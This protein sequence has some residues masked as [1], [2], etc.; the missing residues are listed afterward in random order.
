MH[1]AKKKK[2]E[3]P[4]S[5]VGSCFCRNTS[6]LISRLSSWRAGSW[7]KTSTTAST[8]CG[9]ERRRW[10]SAPR[11]TPPIF[12]CLAETS[13]VWRDASLGASWVCVQPI[14]PHQGERCFSGSLLGSDGSSLPSWASSQSAWGALRQS[15]K[16]LS[17]EFAVLSD[18]A[19]QQVEPLSPPSLHPLPWASKTFGNVHRGAGKRTTSWK[20]STFSWICSSR[21][22]W[23]FCFNGNCYFSVTYKKKTKNV[24][25]DLCERHEKGVLHEHQR[26][27]HKYSVMK[28][29]MMSA[30]V[31]PK[32]QASVEQ[33]ESR[34][35]QV[36]L[37]P[38]QDASWLY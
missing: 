3:L 5:Y 28:R 24:L 25:Q 37:Q 20:S 21:T 31:Q 7:S 6:P 8:G 17:V 13:G 1:L 16:S 2:K 19:A 29:Q 26:A 30:T 18:K 27:L 22:E 15:L 11:R 9:T 10:P 38:S 34:I 12:W 36:L 35:V 4:F 32:E 23:D 33:L 14:G